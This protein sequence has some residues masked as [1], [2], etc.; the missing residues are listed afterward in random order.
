MQVVPVEVEQDVENQGEADPEG[1]PSQRLAHADD[2]V[3]PVKHAQI[4]REHQQD[5]EDEA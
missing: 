2:A 5:E 4:E 1:A 3:V